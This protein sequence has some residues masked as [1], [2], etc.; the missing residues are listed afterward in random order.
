MT[1]YLLIGVLVSA[2]AAI[3]LLVVMKGAGG[4][5]LPVVSRRLMTSREREVITFIEEAVPHCRVHSQVSMGALI[6][7][8]KGLSRKDHVAVR[9][10]FD[11]KV[12]DFVLE[13]RAS[14]D[15]L[16]LIELDDRTHN[17]AKDRSRDEITKAAGYRTVRFAAGKRLDR[18]AVREQILARLSEPA[19]AQ[20]V[21]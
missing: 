12:V 1:D 17:T 5:L 8:K 14:G 11:R 2:A 18:L 10:R 3:G 15:V 20:R 16:A 9:N 7:A 6:E 21:G 19:A 4:S 13:D